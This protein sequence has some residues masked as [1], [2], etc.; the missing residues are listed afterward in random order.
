MC[1]LCIIAL[2][3][4]VL[5]LSVDFFCI[6][7]PSVFGFALACCSS[8]TWTCVNPDPVSDDVKLTDGLMTLFVDF[9]W[10]SVTFQNKFVKSDP[11]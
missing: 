7:I 5:Y 11:P 1:S 2:S 8:P 6:V 4:T 9:E 3:C 10:T